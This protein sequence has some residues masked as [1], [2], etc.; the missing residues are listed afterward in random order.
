MHQRTEKLTEHNVLRKLFKISLFQ[1]NT[2]AAFTHAGLT[3]RYRT[4]SLFKLFLCCQGHAIYS[5]WRG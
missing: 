1:I 2:Y 5:L 3:T 4:E